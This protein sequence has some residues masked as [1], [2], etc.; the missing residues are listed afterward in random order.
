MHSILPNLCISYYVFNCSYCSKSHLSSNNVYRLSLDNSYLRDLL[1]FQK[2]TLY[3]KRALSYFPAMCSI[4]QSVTIF[5]FPI[6]EQLWMRIK[7][8]NLFSFFLS[9]QKW[10]NQNIWLYKIFFKS[11][12]YIYFPK[13]DFYHSSIVS[14][15][16]RMC[17]IILV[18]AKFYITPYIYPLLRL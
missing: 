14:P 10:M 9:K 6:N 3:D 18:K 1:P 15:S 7:V 16:I 17:E 8:F 5:H 4:P 12:N 2:V 11:H 13:S